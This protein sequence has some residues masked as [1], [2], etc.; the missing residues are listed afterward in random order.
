[1][2][3]VVID[4]FGG[5]EVLRYSE[6]EK[7]VPS[8][9]EVLVR[10]VYIGVG[11]PDFLVR[12]GKDTLLA[13]KFPNL[14]I[15]NEC[16]GI[17]EDAGS[18]ATEFRPGQKVVVNSGLG[19]GA[20]A[21]Y[22]AVP[23]K[24]VTVL[25]DEYP[26]QSAPGFLN[27]LVAYA[28]LNEAGRGTDG[29]S[30]YIRGAAGGIGTALIQTALLQGIDVIASASTD[31]KCD[32]IRT[33]GAKC[34]FN[35]NKEQQKEVILDHTNGRGVDLIY[36]QRAGRQFQEQFACLAD[37][38]MILLYNWLE[39]CP[40]LEQLE[41]VIEQANHASAVRFFSFH[42]YDNKPERLQKIRQVCIERIVSG[43]LKPV[44]Y[45][46]LPLS[47]AR[48]AHELMDSGEIMGKLILHV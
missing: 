33:L 10:N 32:Y 16:A 4:R 30:L 45:D 40:G 18:E 19:Y 23:K 39:G 26:L 38:G 20:Y 15:G 37:F 21:E 1:M 6:V 24:F 36:D 17:I 31:K 14:V 3:A 5:P 44:L 28:L 43:Q 7:P 42:V 47:E 27:Y 8:A 46:D 2:K 13:G 11:K 22:I 9:D 41:T 35:Y 25:P 48:R 29:H 34:V 12:S